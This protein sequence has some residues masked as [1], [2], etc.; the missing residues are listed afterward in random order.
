MGNYFH[1]SSELWIAKALPVLTPLLPML[2]RLFYV[3]KAKKFHEFMKVVVV[4]L[5]FL[6]SSVW[7]NLW[8]LYWKFFWKGWQ[9]QPREL[10]Q[11]LFPF[12]NVSSSPSFSFK[13]VVKSMTKSFWPKKL[14]KTQKG[15][16]LFVKMCK[17]RFFYKVFQKGVKKYHKNYFAISKIEFRISNFWT[18][19]MNF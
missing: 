13:M 11:S 12:E 15:L 17:L 10:F 18:W 3:Q 16:W 9:F 5:F 6:P 14:K 8:N 7:N 2:K 4:L 19:N 1:F